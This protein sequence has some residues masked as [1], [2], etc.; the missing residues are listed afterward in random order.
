MPISGLLY[1]VTPTHSMSAAMRDPI[2]VVVFVVVTMASCGI[3]SKQW[4]DMESSSAGSTVRDIAN[5]LR[6]KNLAI[7]GHR[8]Q[9][10]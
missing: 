2:Q 1:Y 3:L 8:D 5:T 10:L 9:S 7:K 6:G 4:M